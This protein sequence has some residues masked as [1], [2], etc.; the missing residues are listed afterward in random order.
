M[1]H[2]PNGWQFLKSAKKSYTDKL[3][4]N[5]LGSPLVRLVKKYKL[6]VNGVIQVGGHHGEEIKS[7]LLIG[8]K[9][10]DIF[11]P[12]KYNLE[13]LE[14][15]VKQHQTENN[16]IIIHPFALGNDNKKVKMYVADNWAASSSILQPQKHLEYYPEIGFSTTELVDMFRLDK[17]IGKINNAN[18]LIMDT[19]GYEVEVLKGATKMLETIDYVYS[20]IAREELYKGCAMI[21]DLDRLLV[22]RGFVRACTEWWGDGYDGNAL[23]IRKSLLKKSRPLLYFYLGCNFITI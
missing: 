10:I 3:L 20:E 6:A 17:F 12:V 11:E 7:L 19:Q 1:D 2:S 22:K 4:K 21:A 18:F 5:Y 9:R 8:I 16:K 23:Y 14:Y 13:R 15:I